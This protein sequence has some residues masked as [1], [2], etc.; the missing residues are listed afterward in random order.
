MEAEQE[1][2]LPLRISHEMRGK[3]SYQG[4]VVSQEGQNERERSKL[5]PEI[6]R[7]ASIFRNEPHTKKKGT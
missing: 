2:H 6:R 4:I 3:R 1:R 7:Y 5:S